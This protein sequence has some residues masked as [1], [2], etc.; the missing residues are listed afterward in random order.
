MTT[1]VSPTD[2][3]MVCYDGSEDAKHAIR[4]AAAIFPG[5]HSLVVTIWQPTAGLG[6]FAW[7]VR[8][9]AW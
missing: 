7:A 4:R 9:R 6:S 3:L 2:P 1:G 5:R 8:P